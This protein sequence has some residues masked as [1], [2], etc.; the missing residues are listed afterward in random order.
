MIDNH[1]PQLGKPSTLGSPFHGLLVNG[2]LTDEWGG[3]VITAPTIPQSTESATQLIKVPGMPEPTRTT[4][5]QTRDAAQGYEWR[6]YALAYGDGTLNGASLGDNWIIYI[7]PAKT[8]WLVT[9]Q[10]A[11]TAATVRLDKIFGRITGEAYPAIERDLATIAYGAWARHPG[12]SGAQVFERNS[13]GSVVYLHYYNDTETA[14]EK[15]TPIRFGSTY[16][17]LESL[18][19]ITISGTG[20]TERTTLGDGITATFVKTRSWGA[21][22]EKEYLRLTESHVTS[23]LQMAQTGNCAKSTET[24]YDPSVSSCPRT[25]TIKSTY[26]C[27]PASFSTVDVSRK[28]YTYTSVLRVVFD[29]TDTEQEISVTTRLTSGKYYGAGCSGSV[30]TTTAREYDSSCDHI[31]SADSFAVSGLMTSWKINGASQ[32]Y[33]W[34]DKIVEMRLFRGGVEVDAVIAAHREHIYTVWEST[35]NASNVVLNETATAIDEWEVNGET[36]PHATPV[37]LYVHMYSPQVIGIQ[38]VASN[39]NNS[40]LGAVATPNGTDDKHA[41]VMLAHNGVNCVGS[42]QP[43]DGDVVWAEPGT[44][45]QST[46]A[47]NFI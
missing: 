2:T 31:E 12:Q 29:A 44:L 26:S 27:D 4:E 9:L 38:A 33:G 10:F 21:L 3:S 11:G 28:G 32:G 18:F 34:S 5:E 1:S 30:Q 35:R 43:V 47:V 15:T 20:S 45:D 41:G 16:G 7:D 37:T 40:Y 25:T 24:T 23:A 13:T 39:D 8:P 6:D 17:D 36:W 46:A 19:K 14:R 42:H 22:N